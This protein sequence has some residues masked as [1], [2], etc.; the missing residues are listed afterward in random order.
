[1]DSMPPWQRQD[2][3]VAV[4]MVRRIPESGAGTDMSN[5][6]KKATR[7]RAYL[8]LGI[9]GGPG[10]GKTYSGLRLA[11]GMAAG[12]PIAGVDTENGSMCLY[13][14]A[15]NFD[16]VTLEPPFTDDKFVQAIDAAVTGG[17]A[18]VIIDSFS[19]AWEAVL[20]YK[21][22]LDS[23]GGNSYI[24]WG[25]AGKKFKSVLAAVLQSPIHVLCCLRTKMEYVL[26]TDLRGKQVPKKVGLQPIAREGAEYEYSTV[27][28]IGSDHCATVSK[29]R[30]GLFIDQ[31]FQ[32]TEDTGRKLLDWLNS[33][34]PAEPTPTIQEQLA[35]ALE[36]MD[37]DDVREFLSSRKVADNILTVPAEYAERSLRRLPELKAA[38]NKFRQDAQASDCQ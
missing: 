17:Y 9:T 24:N 30:T 31:H 13:A 8:K 34:A 1:M 7:R 15:F 3:C 20:D 22:T 33:A 12:Q 36:D 6:F 18:V 29:D 27:F 37:P 11:T 38:I 10:T 5:P 35:A 21:T 32:V 19:H 25:A 16:V 4:R 23:K 14:D 28:D 2:R 26:E